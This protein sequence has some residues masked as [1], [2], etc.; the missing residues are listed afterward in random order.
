MTPIV[1]E[2]LRKYP[3]CY[4]VL[5]ASC[6]PLLLLTVGGLDSIEFLFLPPHSAGPSNDVQFQSFYGL[7]TT[8]FVHYTLGHFASNG[9]I[10][11][12]LAR[13]L[14]SR[15]RIELALL[16]V[17]VVAISNY[18]EWRMEGP[19]FGGLSGLA[20]G[21]LAY[22]LVLKQR[23][24]AGAPHVDPIL[25]ALMLLALPLAASGMVGQYANYAHAAGLAVGAIAGFIGTSLYKEKLS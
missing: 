13:P 21:L 20:Y 17:C 7:W 4:G 1:S 5:L 2:E 9:L 12:F 11:W 6:V 10:W 8:S 18:N 16:S 3:L 23:G 15:S 14:E 24:V 19:D 25:A 22:S